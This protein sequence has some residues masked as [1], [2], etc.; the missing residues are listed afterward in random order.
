MRLAT[1]ALLAILLV[2]LSLAGC[3][4]ESGDPAPQS[5]DNEPPPTGGFSST[6]VFPGTYDTSS[7]HAQLLEAGPYEARTPSVVEL[8]SP[9]DGVA[10]QMAITRP[11]APAGVEVPVILTASTY[12]DFLTPAYAESTTTYKRF[13]EQFVPHGYAFVHL[14]VRGTGGSG[15]CPD[16]LGPMERSDLDHALTWLGS[17]PWSNGNVSAIGISYD[18][19]AAWLA[20]AT[21]NP[22][23]K[24]IVPIEGITDWFQLDYRNGMSNTWGPG[25]EVASYYALPAA[26]TTPADRLSPQRW[27]EH[28]ACPT[29]VEASQAQAYAFNTGERDPGGFW[30]AR[31]L[32]PLVEERYNG[33]IFAVHAFDDANTGPSQT[34][35]FAGRLADQ[36]QRVKRLSGFWG[37][38]VPGDSGPGDLPPEEMRWDWMEIL[39]HWFD[40]ELKGDRTVDLG[41]QVQIEDTDGRWRSA[42]TWPPSDARAAS[43]RL[44]SN[45]ELTEDPGS[46]GSVLVGPMAIV[47]PTTGG[48]DSPGDIWREPA[49]RVCPACPTFATEPVED[50]LRFAGEPVLNLTVTPSGPGGHLT[51]YLWAQTDEGSRLLAWGGTDLRFADGGETG[52]PVVP[53]QPLGVHLTMEPTDAVVPADGKL[54]LQLHQGGYADYQPRVP[55]YPVTVATGGDQ[56]E[57]F[58]RTFEVQEDAFFEPPG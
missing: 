56:S 8:E 3:L 17:Q 47:P 37:H 25:R 5:V 33:S 7:E 31:N 45:G 30:D 24:T 6:H 38:E 34:H 39:K 18:G 15:G 11:E 55:T 35:P 14:A 40:H 20:A 1:G 49:A 54:V 12:F 50:P 13:G 46:D 48:R 41:P 32:R 28:V 4:G 52:K 9:V 58:L 44:G 43:Y 42:P 23:L 27:A 22:H 26:T 29:A 10:I 19:G 16:F 36:D 2:G 21:G 57:L 53:S 51:A